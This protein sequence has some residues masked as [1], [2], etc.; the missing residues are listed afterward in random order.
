ME[1]T[2]LQKFEVGKQY[3]FIG[4]DKNRDVQQIYGQWYSSIKPGDIVTYLGH[5]NDKKGTLRVR[6]NKKSPVEL[7]RPSFLQTLDSKEVKILKTSKKFSQFR[8]SND[9]ICSEHPKYFGLRKSKVAC[10][11]CD[12]I[13]RKV[14]DDK[15]LAAK[16]ILERYENN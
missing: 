12:E 3:V 5:C 10:K 15:D 6:K 7:V 14:M 11:R 13:R 2:K 9:I 1:I 4:Y 8:L 16:L